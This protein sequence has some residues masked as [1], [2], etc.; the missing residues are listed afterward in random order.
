[1]SFVVLLLDDMRADQLGE[2]PL[3]MARLA[4]H[5]VQFERAYVT[6]PMCCPERASFLS[7]G[8]LPQHTGVLTNEYPRGGATRFPD[9]DTLATRLQAAD[10]ATALHG[11]YLN[12]Y[13]DL[14]MYVPP[15]WSDWA[16]VGENEPWTNFVVTAGRSTV[17]GPGLG[18][19][20][21]IEGYYADWIG[22]AGAEFVAKNAENP[23]FL[24][25]SFR[26]PHDPHEPHPD[27]A[28]LHAGVQFRGGAF[29]ELDLSDKPAWV[30]RVP[31]MDEQQLAQF[32]LDNQAR[33]DTFP[34]VDRA[35][36]Q[37]L[38]AIEAQ[39]GGANTVVVL[40]SDNGQ[41]WRE[42]RLSAKGVAYEESVR[43]PLVAWNPSLTARTTT[44]LVATNLDLA[45]TALD[46]A[47][48][49]VTGEGQSL[50]ELFCDEGAKGREQVFLQA[51]PENM[52]N[53]AGL[54]D[55]RWKYIETATGERELYDLENDPFEL[56]NVAT[57]AENEPTVAAMAS[58]VASQ[59]GLAIAT[60]Q[61]PVATYGEP[62]EV[63]LAAWGGEGALAWTVVGGA[64]PVGMAFSPLGVLWGTPVDGSDV[65]I[66]VEVVDESISPVHG[67]PQRDRARLF[68]TVNGGC[69]CESGGAAVVAILGFGLLR[70][71]RR[72]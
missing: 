39:E 50:R 37:I 44:E 51:W 71:S 57:L 63:E 69:D 54:V 53:W 1:L 47:G 43:V 35:I 59:R 6:V 64:L 23:Y 28:G 42:H 18:H 40:T 68:V 24:Y 32:D 70:R 61:M 22:R 7:G 62:Y 17:S 65:D 20:L 46:F 58:Q 41:L 48:A 14:G 13:V 49:D 11:K 72:T 25:S 4:P 60:G 16:A 34:S 67:G 30:Q 10:Y 66:T 2:L 56:E 21:A 27:D 5:A 8:W 45:A 15:G 3:T 29:E 33:L 9:D 55:A 19:E 36:I 31:R 12:D 52:P 26:A 38:D